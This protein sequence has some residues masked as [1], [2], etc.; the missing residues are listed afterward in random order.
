MRQKDFY[1]FLKQIQVISLN[2]LLTISFQAISWTL[3]PLLKQYIYNKWH[4]GNESACN[5][6]EC[7]FDPRVRKIPWRRKWQLLLGNSMDRGAWK[8][9]IH[10]VVSSSTWLSEHTQRKALHLFVLCCRILSAYNWKDSIT[11]PYSFHS[12]LNCSLNLY[13]LDWYFLC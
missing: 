4:S 5:A 10:R 3:S 7:G 13:I 8:A 6:G 9:I 11:Y 2:G 12:P 1:N